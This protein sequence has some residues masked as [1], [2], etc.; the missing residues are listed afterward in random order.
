[1]GDTERA[2]GRTAAVTTGLVTGSQ[3]NA[4][5]TLAGWGSTAMLVRAVPSLEAFFW[6]VLLQSAVSAAVWRLF[7][8]CVL[9]F[10]YSVGK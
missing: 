7:L 3:G 2:V 4:S 8:F 1:M 5:A 9:I 6:H 10:H